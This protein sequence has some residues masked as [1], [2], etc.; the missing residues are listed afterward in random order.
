VAHFRQVVIIL[1]G[2][3]AGR[4]AATEIAGR[5]A[6]SVWVHVVDMPDGKQPDPLAA[7]EI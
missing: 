1:D 4:R 3:E 2:D 7:Q 6:H 5:L